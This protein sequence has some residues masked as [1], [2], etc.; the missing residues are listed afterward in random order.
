M[1][2]QIQALDNTRVQRPEC[3]QGGRWTALSGNFHIFLHGFPSGWVT[4]VFLSVPM[5]KSAKDL[6]LMHRRGNL[7]DSCSG[8]E[9][10]G[11][12]NV[13]FIQKSISLL[14]LRQK[15]RCA[16]GCILCKVWYYVTFHG[17]VFKTFILVH[18]SLEM[19]S[20]GFLPK[21]TCSFGFKKRACGMYD[22]THHWQWQ[23]VKIV[24]RSVL[25]IH[26]TGFSRW[27]KTRESII[28][29]ENAV[30]LLGDKYLLPVHVCC[31][32]RKQKIRMQHHC[33]LPVGNYWRICDTFSFIK[34]GAGCIRTSGVKENT[35]C[36]SLEGSIT[37]FFLSLHFRLIREVLLFSPPRLA[38]YLDRSLSGLHYTGCPHLKL[39]L[40]WTRT[41]SF[42]R[43]HAELAAAPIFFVCVFGRF[44]TW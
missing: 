33:W 32:L 13:A 1:D 43:K 38:F 30:M 10:L 42:F 39:R 9:R 24:W 22:G 23:N 44:C 11:F 31:S 14:V 28:R 3:W 26:E 8:W 4:M 19:L 12:I 34:P 40:L 37:S 2:K 7:G 5:M 25:N 16:N 17:R 15:K 6:L 27:A 29:F 20:L 36:T 21:Y 41:Q 35:W 18:V